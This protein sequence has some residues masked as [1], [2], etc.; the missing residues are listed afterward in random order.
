MRDDSQAL[1]ELLIQFVDALRH[2]GF[3]EGLMK[4]KGFIQRPTMFKRMEPTRGHV[5]GL[6]Q[7]FR[8]NQLHPHV[9]RLDVERRNHSVRNRPGPLVSP[10]QSSAPWPEHPLVGPGNEKVTT[11]LGE[12]KVLD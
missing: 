7:R 9:V 3:P 11:E 4:R 5:D 6:R 8:R 1:L 2:P 12:A 10:D